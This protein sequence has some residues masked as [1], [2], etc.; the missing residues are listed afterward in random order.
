MPNNRT[1]AHKK[2]EGLFKISNKLRLLKSINEIDLNSKYSGVIHFAHGV[3]GRVMFLSSTRPFKLDVVLKGL[4]LNKMMLPPP[5][6]HILKKSF[7]TFKKPLTIVCNGA[8][9][10]IFLPLVW[11]RRYKSYSIPT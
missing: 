6:H 3:N 2:N 8:A 10:C 4:V 9:T 5:T 11:L 1:S 7:W